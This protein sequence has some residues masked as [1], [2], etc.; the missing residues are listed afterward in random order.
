MALI[1]VLA[2]WS[3]SMRAA[4]RDLTVESAPENLA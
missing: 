4:R 2:G 1:D 3:V